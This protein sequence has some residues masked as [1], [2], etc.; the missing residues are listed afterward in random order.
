MRFVSYATAAALMSLCLSAVADAQSYP[1]KSIRIIV[2][3]APGGG[4]DPQARLLGR[5]FQESMGQT[6]VIENRPGAASMIG[7]ELVVRAPADGYTLLCAA[8]TLAST[9]T[10]N[11]KLTFDLVRDLIPVSQI[12]S[13]TQFL[14]VH[15][16]VPATSLKAF[17]A[18]AK[19]QAGKLNA[20]SGGTGST[21]HFALEML[22]Q[23][24]G[25]QATHIPYKGS[26]PATIALIGGEVDFSFAGALSA[27]PHIRSGKIRALAVSTL[28]ISPTAPTIPTVASLY[29]GFEISNWYAIFAPAATPAAIVNKLSAEIANALKS[30]EVRDFMEKEG[31]DAVGSTPREFAVFFMQEVER[32]AKLI[33]TANIRIE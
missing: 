25:I 24:A 22:K 13:T 27:L 2:P 1:I 28:K 32:H 4:L 6:V 7:T 26:G 29:P 16:S 23:R 21:N 14:V 3:V 11:K 31:A 19:Q 33:Q 10:L 17:I 9:V 18:L 12:S 15:S 30:P 5:K 20:G 8:S